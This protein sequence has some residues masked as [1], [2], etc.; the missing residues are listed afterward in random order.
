MKIQNPTK[1][2]ERTVLDDLA[3]SLRNYENKGLSIPLSNAK[4]KNVRSM[5]FA[6]VGLQGEGRHL[7]SKL[8]NR[9]RL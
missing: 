3:H 7:G 6:D 5:N 1:T 8:G 4:A 9:I 2:A